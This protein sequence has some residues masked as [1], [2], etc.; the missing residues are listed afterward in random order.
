MACLS[1]AR[2]LGSSGGNPKG[3]MGIR[4]TNAMSAALAVAMKAERGGGGAT[5]TLR[6][7]LPA[8]RPAA[9]HKAGTARRLYRVFVGRAFRLL[10]LVVVMPGRRW[11]Q[12]GVV[13]VAR[14][15]SERIRVRCGVHQIVHER[16]RRKRVACRGTAST[17]YEVICHRAGG[18]AAFLAL[19]SCPLTAAPVCAAASEPAPVAR[20]PGKRSVSAS[21][22]TR[23]RVGK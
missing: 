13:R 17:A 19:V 7:N 21:I 3:R 14:G 2:C 10:R 15:I 16:V 22:A 5:P 6:S 8:R 1:A 18:C 11:D 12:G 20:A 4:L 23:T 9:M